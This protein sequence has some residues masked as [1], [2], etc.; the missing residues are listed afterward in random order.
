MSK[1]YDD[2]KPINPAPPRK[3]R[4]PLLAWVQYAII[5]LLI[6]SY[7]CEKYEIGDTFAASERR[8]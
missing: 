3:R 5:I 1:N 8:I 2:Y 6:L 7:F 4:N